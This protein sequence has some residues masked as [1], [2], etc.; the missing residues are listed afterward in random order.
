MLNESKQA[1]LERSCGPPPRD[2]LRVAPSRPG[3]ERF[4]AFFS[5]H[6]YEPHRHDTYAIGYTVSGVQCFRYR[7]EQQDSTT[8]HVIV[9]HPDE[10]HDGRAGADGGF[11]YRMLYVEPRL[12]GD[13]LGRGGRRL[14][15][16]RKAVSRDRNL[17]AILRAAL[18]DFEGEIEELATDQIVLSLAQA[19]V[20]LEGSATAFA[21]ISSCATAVDR[22]RQFLDAHFD[23]VVPSAELELV[24]GLDRYSLARHFRALLGTSPYRYL[25]MRRLDHARALMRRGDSIADAAYASGFADQSHMTRCF[26]QAY[27]LPPGRWRAVHLAG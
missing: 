17:L 13:A 2:W 24:T 10:V 15:F 7:G 22:A 18:D 26:K 20:A 23:R 1:R 21:H 9:I 5:G 27:G 14:P 3:L 8:G 11:H 25:V 16:V 6:A 19:L 12:I 4:E